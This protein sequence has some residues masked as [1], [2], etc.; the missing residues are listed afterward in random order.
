[1]LSLENLD[2]NEIQ[3]KILLVLFM[4]LSWIKYWLKFN[5]SSCRCFYL[6]TIEL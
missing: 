5:D 3:I 6:L 2:K 1:M 4:Y